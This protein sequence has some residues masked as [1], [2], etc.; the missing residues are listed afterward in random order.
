MEKAKSHLQKSKAASMS[1]NRFAG[2]AYAGKSKKTE[3]PFGLGPVPAPLLQEILSEDG[4]LKD[5]V[6]GLMSHAIAAGTMGCYA[7]AT[8]KFMNFCGEKGYDYPNFNEK[9]V[10]HYVIQQDKDSAS[11]AALAQ[12]KPALSLVE[13]MTGTECSAFTDTV[14]ML[15][16]AAKR[17]AAEHREPVEKADELPDDVLFRLYPVCFAPHMDGDI[18]ADPILLRTFVRSVIVYFTFCRFSCY[19]KLRAKDL[20][21]NRNSIE[22]TFPS[23]KNDQFHKGNTSCIVANDSDI[24]PVVIVREYFRLCGF[25]FGLKNND[26]SLLNCHMRRTKSSWYADGAHGVAYNTGTKNFR[27][28]LALIGIHDKKVTD[29]SMKMKGVTRAL[30]GD[31]STESVRQQGRWATDSMPLHYLHSSLQYREEIA[32]Q[33]PV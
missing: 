31:M 17:R 29:K 7:N 2:Y 20:E 18:K 28:M 15:L 24:N 22:I 1:G 32:G 16:S 25:Q 12:I 30:H 13:S 6:V 21:D 4:S 26:N 9:A 23:A 33:V 3:V 27:E 11:M 19:S 14:D 5:S 8:K 10:M